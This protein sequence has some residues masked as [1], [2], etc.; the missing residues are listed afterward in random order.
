[1]TATCTP[2]D[3]GSAINF[4]LCRSPVVDGLARLSQRHLILL[5]VAVWPQSAYSQ[6]NA[7]VRSRTVAG[8]E[9]RANHDVLD[10][11]A[12]SVRVQ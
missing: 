8:V 9:E 2:R 4:G 12:C 5:Q 6:R 11:E 7:A 3:V 10:V 1:M